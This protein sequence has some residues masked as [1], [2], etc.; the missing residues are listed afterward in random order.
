MHTM[1]V[2]EAASAAKRLRLTVTSV[3]PNRV[4]RSEWPMMNQSA[5]ASLIIAAL[6]QWFGDAHNGRQGGCE[7]GQE[8][9]IDRDVGLAEQGAPYRM[10]DDDP[11]RAGFLDHRGADFAGERAFSL[12]EHVLR[13]HAHV[14][15]TRR[16]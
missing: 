7:R 5:P 16:L 9:A 11:I 2:R 10:A 14:R 4:R 12:P 13:R 6:L 8:L 15:V 1:G 3:S